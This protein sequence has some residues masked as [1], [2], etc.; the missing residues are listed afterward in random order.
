MSKQR[1]QR[2][3][4]EIKLLSYASSKNYKYGKD[5]FYFLKNK[6]DSR[7]PE[8]SIEVTKYYEVENLTAL[9]SWQPITSIRKWFC[10]AYIYF[11]SDA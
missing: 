4:D 5:D 8:Y 11:L 9:E 2:L 7:Y 1:Y 3:Y 10:I 6:F